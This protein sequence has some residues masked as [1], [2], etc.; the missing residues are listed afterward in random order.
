MIWGNDVSIRKKVLIFVMIIEIVPMLLVLLLSDNILK[1]QIDKAAQIYLQN[2]F[3]IAYNQILNRSGEMGRASTNAT[4]SAEFRQALQQGNI[5]SINKI[6]SDVEEVYNYIDFYMVFDEKK[7]LITSQPATNNSKIPRLITL[8]DEAQSNNTTIT[9]EELLNL[10]DLFYSDSKEYKKFQILLDKNNQGSTLNKY[11]TKCLAS[12]SISP[13]YN[14]ESNEQEGFLVVGTIVNNGSYFPEAYSKSVENSF[15]A[16]SIEGIRVATNIQSPKKANYIGTQMPIAT[17]ILEGKRE[18]YFGR[19]DFDDETHVFLDKSILNYDGDKVAVIGVGIPE[20]KLSIIMSIQRNIIIFVTGFCLVILIFISRYVAKRI[21]GPIIMATELANQISQGNNE[22]IVDDRFLKEKNSETT[23]LLKAFQKMASDLMKDEEEIKNY[24][25]KLQNEHQKQ[26]KLSEQLAELNESLEE[27]VKLRT[28]DLHEAVNS[29][30]KSGE[31]KSL[32][33]ANMSHEL[34]TPLSSI[35]NCSEMLK[36]EMFGQLNDKQQKYIGNILGSGVHLLQLINDV[37]DIS[38]IEA[39]KMTLVLGDYSI[40]NIVMESFFIV[41]SL[42][43]R[44]NIDVRINIASSDFKVKVDANK[45]K[46]ILC[47]LLSNAIK[48]TPQDGKVEVEVFKNGDYFQIATKDNGIGI[49]E[50]DQERIFKEFEQVDSSYERQYEGTGL[51]LPLTKKLV[52]LHN[53]KIFLVSQIG[54]GTEVVVTLP[55]N[56]DNSVNSS[57]NIS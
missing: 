26:Q 8:I 7:E 43:Y 6:I 22:V 19:I 53:G 2:A 32:F 3:K 57:F 52:E 24:L 16:I 49:K 48:F 27:K 25:E 42:A 46:Q 14:E 30:K 29:L 37:L 5:T 4:K 55:I 17:G 56:I 34:R 31:I 10:E 39:G 40:S 50:E 45:L 44:K 1:V 13:V 54:K 51:G 47:N 35:I 38:K 41:K 18:E 21:T 20:Y 12:V 33:L 15:L 28:Q 11:L 9:S 23:V 36:E